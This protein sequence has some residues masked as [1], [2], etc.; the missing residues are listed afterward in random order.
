MG[1]SALERH[2][3]VR[4]RRRTTV[5]LPTAIGT[6][7]RCFAIEQAT[8][9]GDQRLFGS[10]CHLGL[11]EEAFQFGLGSW[12]IEDIEML[13]PNSDEDSR[14]FI[15]TFDE[16]GYA[17]LV[18]VPEDSEVVAAA[19]LAGPR[20]LQESVRKR[21]LERAA[22]IAGRQDY[23]R[24]LTILL[25]G[26]IGRQF[27]SALEELS[28]PPPGWHRLCV[29]APD[30]MLLGEMPDFTAMRAWKL[31]H[32]VDE[33]KTRGILFTNPRGIPQ[34]R[35]LR[36]HG[37]F[38][39]RAG[40]HQCGGGLSPQR[41]HIA[42]PPPSPNSLGPSRR[43]VSGRG[44]MG[45]AFSVYR[46]PTASTKSKAGGRT[47]ALRTSHTGRCWP[48]S[49]PPCARGGFT[50]VTG[51]PDE[52]LPG[53]IVSE[54]LKVA[55]GW[56]ARLIPEFEERYP[57]LP[58]GPVAFQLRFPDIGKFGPNTVALGQP[59]EA[60][61][62]TVEDGRIVVGCGPRYLQRFLE[63]G[64]LGDRLMIAAM[65]RGLEMICR[66][67]PLPNTAMEEWVQTV[68]GSANDRFLKII[69]SR[70]LDGLVYG[71]ATPPGIAFTD[72]GGSG[73]ESA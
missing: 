46:R 52:P 48:A 58:R 43:N 20:P 50:S 61:A 26:G 19:R 5:A 71:G 70:T 15:G 32:Q 8:A 51:I 73:L 2:P 24:G 45:S 28:A 6:A 42:D 38:R 55:L 47:S 63:P 53:T 17:H 44:C 1:H 59:S 67:E 30:F 27:S 54:V 14:E 41:L 49:N 3:L 39:T 56:L 35:C 11:V 37:R 22:E 40:R 25:H 31:L 66:N 16:G 72:A 12:G 23:R 18:F 64:N 33:L 68:A 62:V 65:A 9:A 21:I 36:I 69:P 29:S 4:F 10:T 60:P 13:E 57:M 34:P 7:I